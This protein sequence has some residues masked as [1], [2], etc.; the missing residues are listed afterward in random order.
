[1]V[2]DEVLDRNPC[3]LQRQAELLLQSFWQGWVVLLR[4]GTVSASASAAA[5]RGNRRHEQID[6]ETQVVDS[7][8]IRLID[9]RN[10]GVARQKLRESPQTKSSLYKRG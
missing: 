4:I 1:M 9:H 10:S 5:S 8:K 3:P 6:S 7:R 2:H